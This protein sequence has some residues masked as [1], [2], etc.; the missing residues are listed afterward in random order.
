MKKQ[1][2]FTIIELLIVIAITTILLGLSTMNLFSAKYKA[3]LNSTVTMLIADLRSQQLKAMVG[4]TEGSAATNPG[5]NGI[6]FDTKQYII[7][8]GQSYSVS[9]TDNFAVPLE[10]DL[11]FVNA[12]TSI[13]FSK[14]SGELYDSSVTSFTIQLKNTASG[15]LKYIKINKLGVVNAVTATP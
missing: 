7:F 12:G 15:E 10:G 5:Y 9:T 3:S 1:N 8:H 11:T 4:D 14:V 13:I 2:G 6:Y